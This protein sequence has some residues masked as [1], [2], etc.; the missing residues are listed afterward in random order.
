[1][2][3]ESVLRPFWANKIQ[4]NWKLGVFLILIVCI[5]RFYLVLRA[6]ETGSYGSI[7]LVM[8]VSALIPFIFLNGKGLSQMGIRQ[9]RRLRYLVLSLLLG[10][11]ASLLLYGLG[12]VLFGHTESNW[13]VYI[14]KSYSI[15][16]DL[17]A[18]KKLILFSITA[19][20]A[21]TFSPIGEEFFFRGIVHKNFANSFGTRRASY[22]DSL[23]FAL[24][25][26]AHFGLV[27]IDGQWQFYVLPAILWLLAMFFVCQ[28]FFQMKQRCQ[29]MWGT[30]ICH[31]G[32]NLGM[33]WSIFYGLF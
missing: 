32:F 6:N 4:L 22:I 10:L 27:Y 24:V 33:V 7:A 21:M 8:L 23:A 17:D 2:K 25:H 5:P 26:L 3:K 30:V 12:V 15:G 20:T 28:L 19:I 1:M 16:Q 13:Y 18:N 31:A 11:G 29:S 9:T 14:G